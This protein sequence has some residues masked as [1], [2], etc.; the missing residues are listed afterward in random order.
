MENEALGLEITELR[1]G[2]PGRDCPFVDKAG[3]KREFSQAVADAD[4]E[5]SSSNDGNRQAKGRVV[6]WPPICS[7]RQKNSLQGRENDCEALKFYVKISLDG[8]PFLR[9]IDLN[10]Y[11][12]YSE[13]SAA[14]ENLFGCFGIGTYGGMDSE[15][16]PIY[17]DKDGDWMLIGDVP[18]KMFVESCKRLRVM[19]SSEAMGFGLQS[20]SSGTSSEGPTSEATCLS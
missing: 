15:Y 10:V 6:G 2:L 14:I 18:W 17:E 1:L 20:R 4:D 7:Y 5:N 9:K 19:K 13:L 12:G 8:A 16:I 11:K 3:K